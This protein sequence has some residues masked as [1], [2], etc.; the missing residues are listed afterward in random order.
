M[1]SRHFSISAAFAAVLVVAGCRPGVPIENIS[2]AR[3]SAVT[4]S[5]FL[6]VSDYE[7]AI[8]RAGAN[9][10]WR[11]TKVAS[12]HLQGDLNVRGKHEASVDVLFNTETYS[13][14]YKSSQGLKYD[15]A[16]NQIHPNY[17]SWIRLLDS[18]IQREITLLQNS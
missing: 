1:L 2:N 6:Q 18:D 11:F 8:I 7:R 10:D 5:N 12:G 16:T 17:N 15:P 14:N 9:R 3:Y 13:I 4:S